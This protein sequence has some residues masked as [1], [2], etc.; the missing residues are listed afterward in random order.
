MQLCSC[1]ATT[2][3]GKHEQITAI[4]TLFLVLEALPCK[5][6]FLLLSKPDSFQHIFKAA[7]NP[8]HGFQVRH[9]KNTNL[10]KLQYTSKLCYLK[11][12]NHRTRIHSEA[13][14]PTQKPKREHKHLVS[15]RANK[16]LK[17]WI[18]HSSSASSI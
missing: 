11:K 5:C 18:L 14:S 12:L 4:P 9:Q 7:T 15:H 1:L 2:A 3:E 6:Y 13:L 17:A 10:T 8:F 16:C